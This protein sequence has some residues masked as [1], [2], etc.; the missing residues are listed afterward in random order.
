MA[1]L[2]NKTKGFEGQILER[3][4][5]SEIVKIKEKIKSFSSKSQYEELASIIE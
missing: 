1:D 3:A 4:K 2:E 5:Y